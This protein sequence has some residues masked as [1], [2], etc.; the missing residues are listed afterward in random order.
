MAWRIQATY[1][2]AKNP[3]FVYSLAT[4]GLISGLEL[5]LGIIV[6]CMPTIPPILQAYVR[7]VFQR[8]TSYYNSRRS[9]GGETGNQN[10]YVSD[11]SDSS[12]QQQFKSTP[13]SGDIH[14][15]G[16]GGETHWNGNGGP[17]VAEASSPRARKEGAFARAMRAGTTDNSPY[18]TI[19]DEARILWTAGD[20][21]APHVVDSQGR[22]NWIHVQH[23][24]N[25]SEEYVNAR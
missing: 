15:S 17:L 25:Q 2:S 16:Y 8:L 1:E 18:A 7:P 5:W 24:F 21:G 19:D 9:R 13:L 23:V 14:L 12:G 4:V 11:A 3:D 6:V 22:G 10:K 20:G